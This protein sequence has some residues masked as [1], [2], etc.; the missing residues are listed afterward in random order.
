[1]PLS[2]VLCEL[3]GWPSTFYL[4]A[5][6][7]AVILLVWICFSA[8]KPSKHFCVSPTERY[9]VECAIEE[10]RLGK[11]TENRVPWREIATCKPLYAGVAALICHEYPLV[12]MLQ[13]TGGPI[14]GFVQ[15][16]KNLALFS[17]YQRISIG[18]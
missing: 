18:F 9:F 8:D 10:E 7:G 17:C 2:G 11:R 4:S 3:H 6:I 5:L 14:F 12:I 13:V 1:M 15:R 16:R